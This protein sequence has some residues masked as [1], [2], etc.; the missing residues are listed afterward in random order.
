MNNNLENSNYKK[1]ISL[2]V[3]IITIVVALILVVTA[4]IST[5]VA[6][7]SANITMFSKDLTEIA[8]AT[9]EYYMANNVMP[10]LASSIVMDKDDLLS[11]AKSRSLFLQELTENNDLDSQFYAIDLAKI[12]VTKIGYGTR[13]LGENDAFFISFP[14]MK[15]YYPY[16][17]DAKGTTYFSLTSKISLRQNINEEQVDNSTTSVTS[18]SGVRVTKTDG[19]ANKMGVNIEA[20]IAADE[21]LYMSVSGGT[22]R[23]ITTVTGTNVFGFNLLTSIISNSETIKVPTLTLVEANYVELGN[24][25]LQDRYVD[26][27]KYK[28]A[29]MIGKVRI[30]LSNYSKKLPTITSAS[31]SSYSTMNIV[32]LLLANTESGI[33]EVRYEYLTKYAD[34]GA[35]VNY[36][37]G[38]ADFDS[39][40]MLSKAK[41]AKL[42]SDL[43]TSINAPKNVQSIK[44][45]I[46]DNA[47]NV[48][49]Y[50]QQI[51]QNLYIGYNLDISTQSSLQITANM[52][53]TNG[54]KSIKFSR[55]TNGLS[56][57]DE[58]TYT[59]N[60][61]TNGITTKQ[62][63]K[64]EYVSSN[65]VYIKMVALNYDSTITETRTVRIDFSKTPGIGVNVIA[66]ANSTVNGKTARYSN[67]IIPRGFKAVDTTTIWP[68]DWNT[69]LVIEDVSGNQFVWVP[70]DEID[71]PYAKWGTLGIAYNHVYIVNDTLPTGVTNET[72]QITKYGGFYIGRYEAGNESNIVVSKK[73]VVVWTDIK[74][75]DARTKASEMYTTTEVKSGILTGTQW[76]ATLEWI[77]NLGKSGIDSRAW[78]NHTDSI[79]PANIAGYGDKKVTG[80]SEI[81]KANNLYDIAGNTWEFINETYSD[82]GIVACGGG[83]FD[84]GITYPP[85]YRNYTDPALTYDV[86]G[87]RV[88]L[89]IQ[90]PT[91]V[92]I[93]VIATENTTING[94]VA[95]YNNPIIPKGFKAINDGAVW[96]TDWNLGL[97]IED[98]AGNQF[99]WVPVDGTNVRYEKWCTLNISHAVTANDTLQA[100]IIENTQ[101][102]NYGGFYIGRYESMF[103]YN[104]GNL[105]VASKKTGN[106]TSANWSATRNATYNGYLWNFV[107]YTESKTYAQNMA[108]SYGYDTAKIATNLVT[109]TQWD[110]AM[111]WIQNSGKSVIDSRAWGNHTDAISPANVGNGVLQISGYSNNWKANNIYDLAGNQLEWTNESYSTGYVIRGGVFYASGTTLPASSRSYNNAGGSYLDIGFRVALYIQEP[112]IV[113]INVIATTNSTINGRSASYNNPIIPKGFKAINDGAIW[114]MN[115]N[116]GLVIEDVNGNQFVWVPVDGTNVPYVKWCTTGIAYNDVTL[117]DGTL[118]SGITENT[119]ITK[120]G[121]F[122]IARYEAGKE[123]TATLV[124]KKNATVWVTINYANSKATS[125]AMYTTAEV[126]SG[127]VTG[128]QWDTAMKWIQNSGKSVT[129]S[130]AW[131]NHLDSIAPANVAGFGVKQ[132]AG[133]SEYWKANNIYNLAGNVTEWTNEIYGVKSIRRGGASHISGISSTAA[134]RANVVSTDTYST[135]GFRTALYIL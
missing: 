130:T 87:F 96:P 35:I 33:K 61:T 82:S 93:N 105:R 38:V 112:A 53:S 19:W 100:G 16:G 65:T 39:V 7:D 28:S 132:V 134:T 111:K 21:T 37:T 104:S 45:A 17:I 68:N 135:M 119:Q 71:V 74:Y 81:W 83:A 48:N 125:E 114:P 95:A 11:L 73:N 91:G 118:P 6:I 27:L 2:V 43:T 59:L 127:L 131:D 86:V 126:K 64:Y 5:T 41:K 77:Q 54:I 63:L 128:T 26:I 46:I 69:G 40:Y 98:A 30:D 14:S 47:G 56:F 115:W 101:I 13:S 42:G 44:I 123:S 89:Y 55:S 92:G 76:G 34:N 70:V 20:Q 79:A 67:P 103:D 110:T 120:Y 3:L 9:E 94:K 133:Y 1:G 23:L 12:N 108:T 32:K 29:Q 88:A 84:S 113:G 122:Y 116:T 66:T 49:L 99:V 85:S 97:V 78:G 102:N 51:A 22:N 18:S 62:N 58:Q 80:Y 57:T 24:K 31:L 50:N 36:Y 60:S 25:P 124:S 109:G 90:E 121:G 15:V 4:V 72:N 107:N 52:F 129:N 117:S 10:D 106:R 8:E 75:A